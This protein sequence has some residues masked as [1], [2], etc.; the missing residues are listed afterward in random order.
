MNGH[1]YQAYGENGGNT[2]QF[3]K[4]TEMLEQYIQQNVRWSSDLQPLFT[5]L[6]QPTIK[7]LAVLTAEEKKN[8]F[9]VAVWKEKVKE[10][11]SREGTLEQNLITVYATVWGQTSIAVKAKLRSLPEFERK[12]KESDPVWLLRN[13]KA[14]MMKYES[15]RYAYTSITDAYDQ[16]FSCHQGQRESDSHYLER[17]RSAYEV[18]EHAGGQI[19]ADARVLPTAEKKKYTTE[20]EIQTAGLE[21]TL[22]AIFISHAD[23]HRYAKLQSNLASLHGLNQAMH[24]TDLDAA[25]S[26]LVTFKEHDPDTNR[27][28]RNNRRSDPNNTSAD[29]PIPALSFAQAAAQGNALVPGTNGISH[30]GITCF[31]CQ[32]VGHY[33]NECPTPSTPGQQHVQFNDRG[34]DTIEPTDH[35]IASNFSFLESNKPETIPSSGILIDSLST[36]DVFKNPA[37]LTD[38]RACY[39]RPLKLYTNG[40]SMLSTQQ[41]YL[42]GFG[43]VWYNP[44]SLANILSLASVTKRCR[45]TMDSAVENCINVHRSNGTIMKFTE[46]RSGLYFHDTS[47]P[48]TPETS[49][50]VT[51]YSFLH[52]VASNKQQF[53]RREVE[54]AD[55]ALILQKR[56]GH[57]SDQAFQEYL[58]NGLINN[59]P[60]TVDDHKRGRLIYGPD[61]AMLKGKTVKRSSVPVPS[62]DVQPIPSHIATHHSRLT[63]C[64]DYFYVNT[65]PFFHTISRKLQLRTSASV[66]NRAKRTTLLE[67]NAVLNLYSSRGFEIPDIHADREFECIR[68]D[69]LPVALN[70]TAADDHVGEVER[71]IRTIKERIRCDIHEL[72]FRRITRVMTK[73]LVNKATQDL[74]RFPPGDGLSKTVSPF[75][76]ITGK[77]NPDYHRFKLDFGTLAMVFEENQRTNNNDTRGTEA[78]ALT[79]TGNSQGS[80]YFMSLRTGERITREQYTA[81]PMTDA[82]I[83]RVEQIAKNENMPLIKGNNLSYE[84]RPDVPFPDEDDDNDDNN[85]N[86]DDDDDDDSTYYPDSQ[87]SDGDDDQD[88]D[89]DDDNSN[90]NGIPEVDSDED[91]NNYYAPIWAQDD[92]EDEDEQ[93]E[94]DDESSDDETILAREQRSEDGT[95]EEQRSD[96]QENGNGGDAP[97]YNLRTNRTR[98]YD[99]RLDHQMDE[100]ESTQS[101]ESGVQM[102]QH[103]VANMNSNPQD[104]NRYICGVVLTQMSAKAG[105]EKHGQ[106]AI[107]C[108]FAEFAQLEDRNVFTGVKSSELT[109]EQKYNALRSISLVKEKRT[110]KLKGRTCVDGR[111][112]RSQYT[113]DQTTSPT[114]ST[115]ALMLSIMIDA[116]EGRDVA[117]ADVAGAYLNAEMD[118][119]VILKMT[120]SD[121]GILCQVNPEYNNF[122]EIENGKK[123]LYLRVLKALYGMVKSALL[124]YKLFTE[125]LYDM[126]FRLNPYDACVANSIINQKQATICWYV[127]DNKISHVEPQVVTDII[128]RIEKDFGEMTVTRGK[129]HSF[130]GMDITFNEDNTASILM[131]SYLEE[132]M[133]DVGIDR[134]VTTTLPAKKDLNVTHDDLPRLNKERS[135]IFHSVVMKLL[136]VAKRARGDL[137]PTI[138][139]LSTRV[140]KSNEKDWEK[141]ERL[142]HYLNDTIDDPFVIGAD[143]MHTMYSWV[144]ASYAVHDDMK[145]HTGGTISFGRGALMP[146]SEKQKLNTKSS[147]EAEVVGA[148]DFLPKNIW[149]MNFLAEQGYN[150][151]TN[152]FYQDNQ[153]A[154]KLETNGRASAGKQSRHIDIRYFFIKDRVDNGEITIEHSPTDEMLAD[155]FTKPLQGALFRKFKAVILGHAH[156]STLKKSPTAPPEERVGKGVPVRSNERTRISERASADGQTLATTTSR[157]KNA[158]AVGKAAVSFEQP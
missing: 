106:P 79:P 115:D 158:S 82:A 44:K 146:T 29:E 3:Q 73:E 130:L 30:P 67:T 101:Y 140:S 142:C 62:L 65:I 45:V 47:S 116:L 13:I 80:Y 89:D 150:L 110:G 61:P 10:Y 132:A 23:K 28:G 155:F 32:K 14:I 109:K 143:N 77:P 34:T 42:K 38:I 112:Q 51:D 119:F 105:I 127:D 96:S 104:L 15:T 124:W 43:L 102:L 59:C 120:G 4:T 126:G 27:Q 86:D 141:L 26:A 54:G 147:T 128:D 35:S 121:L 18:L 118:D 50:P 114:I 46:L 90:D 107:D 20:S 136:Y 100:P 92:S 66:P 152:I 41:G 55:K 134:S 94:I 122:V 135:D 99:H 83:A 7:D 36:A 156:I 16:F 25:Y 22:A 48:S 72:P 24:P 151:S 37:F 76:I 57:P 111:P 93:D 33:S 9:K 139:F 71:S 12:S 78:I 39:G 19:G 145:S 108:L 154:I 56:I 49:T 75:S 125:T 60:V 63:L 74:N 157:S 103:A 31:D 149:A 133:S 70:T 84:W 6:K 53:T 123:V 117:T 148:S 11:V 2:R 52:T 88:N 137:L 81:L 68:N 64:A 40:G 113:K 138:S 129:E 21:R 91:T 58:A 95:S 85:N 131:K 153:S 98:S 1:V 69:I 17:F 97:G 87:D 8:E 144:D 5:D